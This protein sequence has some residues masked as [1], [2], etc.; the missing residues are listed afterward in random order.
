MF[1]KLCVS[2]HQSRDGQGV[3]VGPD[4]I[5]FSAIGAEALLTRILDP[6]R[7]VAPQYQPYLF[8]MKDGTVLSGMIAEESPTTVHLL[9]PGGIRESFPREQVASMKGLGVS[10]M[11]EGLEATL[12]HQDMADLIGFLESES[13][14]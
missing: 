13:P 11:P 7:E 14:E 6:G 10:L 9:L 1:A 12:S 4:T 8:T 5:T 3:R 2:C